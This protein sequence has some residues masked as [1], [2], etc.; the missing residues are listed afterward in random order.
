MSADAQA[1]A[2]RRERNALRRRII[3]SL[4]EQGFDLEN[5]RVVLPE[6]VD[7]SELRRLHQLAVAHR[8]ERARPGLERHEASLLKR[9]ADGPQVDPKTIAPRLVEVERDSEEE[10]LFRFVSL[11][12]SIPVSSG[13]GRRL[14]FLVVDEANGK[15]R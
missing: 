2:P 7:K 11:H 8:R 15:P 1:M 10:L 14:R 5:G 4:K 6:P 9:I 3:R 13:Y 12:W